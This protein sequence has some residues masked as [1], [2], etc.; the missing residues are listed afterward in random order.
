MNW[1]KSIGIGKNSG[2]AGQGNAM[3]GHRAQIALEYLILTGFILVVVSI[4]FAF[5]FISYSQNIRMAKATEAV[6]KISNAVD[7][8]YT[9]GPG[10]SRFVEIT[11]PDGLENVFAEHKC[12][13]GS[14]TNQGT[15]AECKAGCT[16]PCSCTSYD[17][18]QFSAVAMEVQLFGTNSVLMEQT[19]AKIYMD[20]EMSLLNADGTLNK[21][22]GSLYSVK[23]S[24]TAGDETVKI[25]KV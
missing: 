23:V 25:E 20:I 22:S 8:V 5:S 13:E 4:I 19:K 3:P 9:R 24:W 14:A 18:V 21:Y 16:A 6:A 17:C 10:N 2:A 7:D 12:I 15:I 1:V 11:L